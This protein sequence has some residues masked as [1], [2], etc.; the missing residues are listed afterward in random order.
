MILA[1][2]AWSSNLVSA[3]CW[4]VDRSSKFS[5]TSRETHTTLSASLYPP[6]MISFLLAVNFSFPIFQIS[7]VKKTHMLIL[8]CGFPMHLLHC[9]GIG[10]EGPFIRI[11]RELEV[12]RH[13]RSPPLIEV[14]QYWSNTR[15]TS[16]QLLC[17]RG[18]TILVKYLMA[19]SLKVV[20]PANFI[21]CTVAIPSI[22]CMVLSFDG[23]RQL[24]TSTCSSRRFKTTLLVVFLSVPS[25]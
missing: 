22:M 15:C 3:S 6:A 5:H 11:S 19:S 17:D 2:L 8:F 9:L 13:V 12:P 7:L 23:T 14:S 10:V 4:S 25:W 21:I 18:D 1:Y 24:T 20:V 16:L